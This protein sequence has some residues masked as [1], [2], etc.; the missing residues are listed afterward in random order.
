M[1]AQGGATNCVLRLKQKVALKRA[2]RATDRDVVILPWPASL[3]I[4]L[5]RLRDDGGLLAAAQLGHAAL[6]H[7]LLDQRGQRNL[8]ADREGITNKTQSVSD[9]WRKRQKR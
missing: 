8:N 9:Q 4:S 3:L 6:G 2:T 5:P 7:G 1:T